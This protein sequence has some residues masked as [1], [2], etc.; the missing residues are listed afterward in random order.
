LQGLHKITNNLC[1]LGL[2]FA[3]YCDKMIGHAKDMGSTMR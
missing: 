3:Y 1:Q 2:R